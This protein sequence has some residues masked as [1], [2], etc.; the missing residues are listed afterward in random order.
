MPVKSGAKLSDKISDELLRGILSGPYVGSDYLPSEAELCE[1]FKVSRP[2]IRDAVRIL[3]G[4]GVVERQHGK[5]I[6]IINKTLEAVTSSLEV[7]MASYEIPI[8]HILEIRKFLEVPAVR[9]AA[10]RADETDV[11][12][13]GAALA[14]MKDM[15]TSREEYVINDLDFHIQI[16]K[17]AKNFI[18]QAIFQSLKPIL[19]TCIRE[20]LVEN[21]RPEIQMHYH[22]NIYD[23]IAKRNPDRAEAFM[24][25]HLEAT[26]M[27]ALEQERPET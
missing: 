14:K 13:M 4:R 6:K 2:T 19:I 11:A 7:M 10:M 21:K 26:Q 27:L 16:A 12:A 15:A 17:A 5:G 25:T 18:L 20:T 1:I 3:V 24:R 23:A 8:E 9:L 22:E